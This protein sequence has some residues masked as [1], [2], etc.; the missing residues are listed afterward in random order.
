MVIATTMVMKKTRPKYSKAT[1]AA[2]ARS[3]TPPWIG[4]CAGG[5][6]AE[7]G[8]GLSVDIGTWNFK[9]SSYD[10]M[11]SVERQTKSARK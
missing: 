4:V 11:K 7:A 1:L 3:V 5:E 8:V 2:M 9:R 10:E 6:D